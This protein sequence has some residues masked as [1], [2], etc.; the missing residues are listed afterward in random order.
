MS[1]KALPALHTIFVNHSQ[2]AKAH[3]LWII[4]VSERKR[5]IT[6]K[7]A[8]VGVATFL[9]SP[10]SNHGTRVLIKAVLK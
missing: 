3:M 1:A 10:K 6:V 7:P 5:M 2:A 8:V 9:A 4:I